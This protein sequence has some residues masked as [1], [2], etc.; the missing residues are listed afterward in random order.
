MLKVF[1][2]TADTILRTDASGVGLGA[3]LSQM[4]DSVE[5]PVLFLS[6]RLT[7]VESRY[8]SNEQ[9]CLALIWAL[10]RLRAYL[11]GRHFKVF[12]DN[13]VL[14]WLWAKQ[15]TS[16]KFARWIIQLQEFDF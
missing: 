7:E 3:V 2:Q 15:A 11:L 13:T 14:K 6:R 5:R 16:G 9:E 12:T 8:H 10:D 1:S 4:E